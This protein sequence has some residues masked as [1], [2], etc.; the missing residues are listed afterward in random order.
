MSAALVAAL[1]GCIAALLEC[2][3]DNA[4][5]SDTKVAEPTGE[6]FVSEQ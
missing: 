3:T 5:T 6:T 1:G 4:V 2:A